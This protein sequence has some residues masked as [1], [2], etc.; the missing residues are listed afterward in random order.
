MSAEIRRLRQGDSILAQVYAMHTADEV[1]K[2]N[3]HL[4][5]SEEIWVGLWDG[6]LVCLW[7]LIPASLLSSNVYM[8]S[9]TYPALAGCK[10]SFV[11]WSERIVRSVLTRY[12]TITGLCTGN[13]AWLRWLGAELREPY[14][15]YVTFIIRP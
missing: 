12:D 13:V 14:R 5:A 11:R 6:K 4:E 9:M 2:I 1:A 7:G 3:E 10:I 8:W 15:G